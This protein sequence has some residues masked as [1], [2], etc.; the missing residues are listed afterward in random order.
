MNFV[1]LCSA[2]KVFS[3][4]FWGHGRGVACNMRLE[5]FGA[6]VINVSSLL[7]LIGPCSS[8]FRQTR[9][10]RSLMVPFRRFFLLRVY[11]VGVIRQALWEDTWTPTSKSRTYEGFTP[12]EKAWIRKWAVEDGVTVSVH[13]F[14]YQSISE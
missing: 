13:H 11:T 1:D 4:N 3:A 14:S 8:T 7:Q 10:Y 6:Y 9:R 2:T 12:E 5:F